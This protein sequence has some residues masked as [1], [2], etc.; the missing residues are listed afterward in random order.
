[1]LTVHVSPVGSGSVVVSVGG[2][3]KEEPYEFVPLDDVVI[4]A[5]GATGYRFIEW[6]G[7]MGGSTNPEHIVV[8][9]NK[10]ITAHFIATETFTTSTAVEI[11]AG[12]ISGTDLELNAVDPS[13]I[14]DVAGKPDNMP[15]GLFDI[16]ASANGEGRAVI[17][18]YLPAP[19]P[20]GYRWY[21]Y[22]E[23]GGWI[24]F[25]RGK[26]S[27][28]T[29]D[30]A[31]FNAARTEVTIYIADNGSYDANPADG[32]INDPSGLGSPTD[33]EEEEPTPSSDDSGGGCF[34]GAIIQ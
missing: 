11:E 26:I 24:D 14:T 28:G 7:N 16:S 34:I 2:V 18:L 15:Y 29:G 30:G 8:N 22:S 9:N 5:Q 31:E 17:R 6:S 12:A 10:D 3:V 23:T 19:A 20:E 21:K 27:G 32:L 1:M 13:T 33:D 25:S 4:E